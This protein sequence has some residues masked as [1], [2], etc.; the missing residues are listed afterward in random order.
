MHVV[1]K[2][3]HQRYTPLTLAPTWGKKIEILNE[4]SVSAVSRKVVKLTL[5]AGSEHVLPHVVWL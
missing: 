1:K 5:H 4:H 2:Y 3:T